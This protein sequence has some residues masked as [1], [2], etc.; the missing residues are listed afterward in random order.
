MCFVWVGARLHYNGV[1]SIFSSGRDASSIGRP[2]NGSWYTSIAAPVRRP[3]LFDQRRGFLRFQTRQYY[4][5]R[6]AAFVLAWRQIR[7]S[8]VRFFVYLLIGRFLICVVLLRG[9]GVILT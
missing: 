9:H 8:V 4:L 3:H 2:E 1:G 7:S 5:A 6:Q